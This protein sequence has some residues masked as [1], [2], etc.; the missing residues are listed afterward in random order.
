[1]KDKFT[2]LFKTIFL[3]AMLCM[4]V[5]VT[6]ISILTIKSFYSNLEFST[7][8]NLKQL[9]IE[10]MTEVELMLSNQI[11]LTKSVAK[12]SYIE[13]DVSKGVNQK[14]VIDY[15]GLI[16]KNADGL[17]ENFFITKDSAGFADCLNG[18]TLHD[19]AGE[20]WYEICKKSGEFLGNNISPVTGRPV[21][22]I[23]YGIYDNGRFI[24]GL[25]NSIDLAKMTSSITGS[26]NDDFTK[27]LII[28]NEGNVIASENSEQILKTNFNKENEST[29]H[30]M[31]EILSSESKIVEFDFNEKRNIGSFAKVGSM[32]TLVYMPKEVYLS[33]ISAVAR[34]TV[35]LIAICVII[36][37]IVIFVIVISITHPIRVVNRAIKEIANGNADLT[38]RVNINAKHEIKS[39]V[40][41]FNLFSQKMQ[42]IIKDVKDSQGE[43]SDAGNALKDST[44]DTESS[45]TQ[46]L[47]NISSVNHRILSQ[48]SIVQETSIALKDI[49]SNL[50]ELNSM[51]SEQSECVNTASNEVETMLVNIDDVNELV[52]NMSK[53]FDI[54]QKNVESGTAKQLEVTKL[55]KQIESE[56]KMLQEANSVIASIASQ[57]NLLA[58]NAA[59]EA[60]HAGE[61]GKGFSVVADEIRKLSETSTLQSKKIGTQLNEIKNSISNVVTASVDSQNSFTEISVKIEK[62]DDSVKKIHGAMEKQQNGSKQISDSLKIMN[63]STNNVLVS[64]TEISNN[65]NSILKELQKLNDASIEM[66]NSIEEMQIGAQ[67]INETGEKLTSI[68]SLVEEA[69]EKSNSQIDKFIV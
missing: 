32:I 8:S 38:K 60:A 17:Y 54:L 65:S 57:T 18:A 56:S 55:V 41:G 48:S 28:D 7:Q 62:T 4:L 51:I 53:D 44:F 47:A 20:P 59:I 9:S 1:M 45:I 14:R 22:V 58:M 43:L 23:S 69:I 26:I 37:I 49:S 39:L 24:G 40:E 29:S 68:T 13:E 66:K 30:L 11:N 42:S 19:V 10:K 31:S 34:N 64:S 2:G 67:K 3:M 52:S 35:F 5:P 33:K 27:V 15:L 21:Y 46:I 50:G 25:N 6:I 12:S 63:S 16:G 61:T 36:S